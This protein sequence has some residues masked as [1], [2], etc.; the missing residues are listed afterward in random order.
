MEE[1]LEPPRP[2]PVARASK[3]EKAFRF[4]QSGEN[5]GK[6]VIE[7]QEDIVP[8]SDALMTRALGGLG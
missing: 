7:I 2:L 5:A 1:K 8:I 4:L 3:T 6:T